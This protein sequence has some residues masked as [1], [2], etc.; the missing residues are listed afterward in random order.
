MGKGVLETGN[1]LYNE[2]LREYNKEVYGR[3]KTLG[4]K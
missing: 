1:I 4:T 3:K 2:R